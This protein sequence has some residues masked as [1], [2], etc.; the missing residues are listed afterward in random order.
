MPIQFENN[1]KFR[2]IPEERLDEFD[3][4]G[5]LVTDKHETKLAKNESPNMANILFND[6]GSIK[7]RNGFVR[8]NGDTIGS[9]SDEANTGASTGSITLDTYGDWVAQTFE[10]GSEAD[11]VQI[12]LY[13][14]MQTSGEEQLVQAQLWSG[15]TGPNEF[16]VNSQVLLVSGN[17]ET[18]Y[19]FRFLVPQTLSASTEY[20]IVLRPYTQ[21]S[22]TD[23]NTVLVHHTAD[24]YASGA[25]YTSTTSGASWVSVPSTDLKFDVYTGGNTGCTGL[26]RFYTDTGI[27]QMFAKFGTTLYRSNDTTGVLTAITLGN[28]STFS[29]D[30]YLDYTITNNTL[31]LVDRNGYIQKYRGST[32]ENYSTGTVSVT[33]GSTAV[34]G[35]GT[36]WNTSTN[37]E[38]GEYIQ[39]PDG[40]WY[41]ITDIGSDTSI[42]IERDYESVSDSGESYVISPWG[43]VQGKLNSSSSPAGLVRPQPDYIEN[44][45]NRI[46]T[47]EGNTLRFSALD[48]SVSEE[49]F[50]DWDTGNNAGAIIL[51]SGDGD[52]GTG[53]YSLNGYL[54]VF[55]R[56]AIWEIFG[57]S[58]S[59]FEL[60]NISN[61]VGMEDK[62]TLVE[63]DRYLFF[64]SGQDV[65]LF[66]GTNFTNLTEN[67]IRNTIRTWADSISPVATLWENKYVITY[68]PN[69][70]SAN[71]DSLFYDIERGV[72]GRFEST[73]FSA[74]TAWNGGNDNDEVYCASSK[75]GVVYKWNTGG[76]DDGFEITSRY[77]T[78]SLGFGAGIN[79]KTVKKFYIQQLAL[80]DWDLGVTMFTDIN[81]TQT[82]STIS[83]LP[84]TTSLWDVALWDVDVWSAENSITTDRI[85]E[86][87][88]IAKYYKFR[89]EQTGYSQ[90]IDILG[91]TLTARMRRL[92]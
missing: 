33:Q 87:Q 39:L 43:E 64:Y 9:S 79:D 61:E 16:V 45:I 27:K 73:P 75:Q 50:N 36:S 34:T 42:S 65:Y 23:I 72:W 56:N 3:F 86:F 29:A 14:E 22:V 20:A 80:G 67:K 83:L 53:L 24:A 18:E 58:P 8:S 76:H 25:A 49:H 4:I 6:T 82:S 81:S 51:P 40:K 5:G 74:W 21:G 38:V 19:S 31:L 1:I 44:H 2:S 85:A 46:W 35:S 52:I 54:Y 63:Y 10:V 32:N 78:P 60:R 57:S 41:Q 91:I 71:S 30:G 88:G 13:L 84:G 37:A 17:S 66:D 59:N 26:V 7:T 47:L 90:G 69:G 11:V 89:F 68:T 92:R 70:E 12:D 55:Q 28:G 77:D 48:T 15:D 62:R